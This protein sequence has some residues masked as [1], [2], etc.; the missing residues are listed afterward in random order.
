MMRGFIPSVMMTMITIG[1][2][3]GDFPKE[4]VPPPRPLAPLPPVKTEPL[5]WT[6]TEPIDTPVS[7]AE[8][9]KLSAGELKEQLELLK[10]E[11]GIANEKP[12]LEPTADERTR[13]RNKL[14]SLV[15][16]LGEKKKEPAPPPAD[17]T[18]ET[19]HGG[20][21]TP[22]PP[23]LTPAENPIDLL[24]ASAN[25]FK[26]GD[27]AT[28]YELLKLVDN[29]QLTKEDRAFADYLRAA[30]LRKAGKTTE[31]L[32]LYRT[33]AEAKDDPLLAEY[34]LVQLNAIKSA[35]ELEA[36]LQQLK[37]RTNPK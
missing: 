25:L 1:S 16:K 4:T 15:E 24:R 27:S 7:P 17:K 5:Q 22:P 36:Q 26:N 32:I 30:S 13:L 19:P 33:I 9:P 2:V 29:N 31:A 8:P 18:H 12:A 14:N 6:K 3:R 10:K 37:S 20:P 28:A 23:T 35:Q 34:A 21:T 11:L